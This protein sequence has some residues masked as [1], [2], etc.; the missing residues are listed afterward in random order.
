MYTQSIL[1]DTLKSF[2]YYKNKLPLY[3]QNSYG[4]AEHFRI[5]FD[6]L[7]GEQGV[8]Q[9]ADTLLYGLN[10]FDE[11]YLDFVE[12][13]SADGA[14]ITYEGQPVTSVTY[15]GES[16]SS[17]YGTENDLLDKIG[18]IFGLSRHFS[19]DVGE[20][21]YELSLNNEDFLTF[22]KARI[23]QN[24]YKGSY[25][26]MKAY[27]EIAGLNVMI[28]TVPD[29]NASAKIYLVETDEISYSTDIK[30]LFNAGELLLPSMGIKYSY[31]MITL[32]QS[33]VF[34]GVGYNDVWDTG[35]WAE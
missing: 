4:F 26:E 23:I 22:I 30:T 34:D 15:E 20:E 10:I 35:E 28:I 17:G 13:Y 5:W 19:V 1:N 16:L 25:E 32:D 6:V 29:E 33:L 8:V 24:H 9:F 27:Y 3:L 12:E 2:D 11:D 21:H 14:S 31:G 18:S 7:M